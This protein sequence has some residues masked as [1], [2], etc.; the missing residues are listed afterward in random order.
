[1]PFYISDKKVNALANEVKRQLGTKTK[2]EA[3]RI[4]LENLLKQADEEAEPEGKS[5]P[6][7]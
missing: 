4:A 2:E 6:I 5:A 3:I 1:M 7:G